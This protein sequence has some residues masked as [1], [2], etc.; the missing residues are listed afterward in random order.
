MSKITRAS[1]NDDLRKR[2]GAVL[3]NGQTFYTLAEKSNRHEFGYGTPLRQTT[4]VTSTT[5][6]DDPEWDRIRLDIITTRSHQKGPAFVVNNLTLQEDNSLFNNPFDV[7]SINDPRP[8]Y[9]PDLIKLS[10]LNYYKGIIDDIETD[11][12]LAD[13][14]EL[15]STSPVTSTVTNLNF[16]SS[17]VW[18]FSATFASGAAACQFFNSG[19]SFKFNF[20]AVSLDG[21]GPVGR[22]SRD[23]VEMLTRLGVRTFAAPQFY[24]NHR[25]TIVAATP[26]WASVTSTDAA[27][28]PVNT[29]RLLASTNN[30]TLGQASRFTIRLSISSG[31]GGGVAIGAGDGFGDSVK[32]SV[33]PQVEVIRSNN[34]IVSPMPI[35][36]NYGQLTA[37]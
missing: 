31:Y 29:A 26:T 19:G 28:N 5:K 36:Y 4:A 13:S 35:S 34:I 21:L 18:D 22:Q 11:K 23:F 25:T 37:A 16:S 7:N 15:E 1:Y 14:T 33:E 9:A 24:A 6:V 20:E 27:Y 17:A 2:L 30:A 32:I 3:D 10:V 12:F 8:G